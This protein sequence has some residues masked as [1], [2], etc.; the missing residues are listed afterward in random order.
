M[1]WKL[2]LLIGLSIA[3][4]A[5]FTNAIRRSRPHRRLIDAQPDKITTKPSDV[6]LGMEAT[7]LEILEQAHTANAQAQDYNRSISRKLSR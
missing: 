6:P 7:D 5:I 4:V 2:W 1:I 3:G